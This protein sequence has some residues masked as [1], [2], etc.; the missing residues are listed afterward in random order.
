MAA[1]SENIRANFDEA[2]DNNNLEAE[3]M[4]ADGAVLG[5]QVGCMAAIFVTC[6]LGALLPI[7]FTRWFKDQ[8]KVL[9]YANCLGGGILLG[10]SY[11]HLMSDAEEEA[12]IVS[13]SFGHFIV[14]VGFLVSFILER[15]LFDHD[16]SHGHGGHDH[17]VRVEDHQTDANLDTFTSKAE[18]DDTTETITTGQPEVE[19]G[20]LQTDTD[21]R[22]PEHEEV[23]LHG[24]DGGGEGGHKKEKKKKGHH[25]HHGHKHEHEHGE[26]EADHEYRF[27]HLEADHH[28]DHI[29][30]T[31]KRAKVPYMLF[32]VLG[33]ESAISGSALGVQS[34]LM[35]TFVTFLAIVTHIWA[36]AFTLSTAMLKARVSVTN[37][38]KAMLGFSCITPAA[39]FLGMGLGQLL[40]ASGVAVVSS[41]LVSFAAGTFVYVAAMEIMTEEFSN[42][43]HKWTKLSLL[44]SGFA[45]M[46]VLGLVM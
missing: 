18:G 29:I 30:H 27:S 38:V 24:E 11:V 15:I 44:L 19:L 28:H 23:E 34:T 13:S 36:E 16:D 45:F 20:L 46:S 8:G 14:A 6:F 12:T 7:Q 21:E 4:G 32:V 37:T 43:H 10:A 39:V 17:I 42:P 3:S 33:L 41:I 9:S 2:A 31:Q 35:K 1:Q 26:H 40:E 5:F 25:H 22:S